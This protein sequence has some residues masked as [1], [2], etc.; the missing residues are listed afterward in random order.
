MVGE[1]I[2]GTYRQLKNLSG[3]ARKR[4]FCVAASVSPWL[5]CG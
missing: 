5:L 3:F 2:E 4:R 1:T